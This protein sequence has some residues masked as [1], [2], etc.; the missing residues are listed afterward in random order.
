MSPLA[1]SSV[2]PSATPAAVLP[3]ISANQGEVRPAPGRSGNVQV[4]RDVPRVLSIAGSDPSGG[5]GVQADLKSI[6]A[7]G[8]YGMAAITAL[9]VQNTQGVQAVH[10]PPASFL[11]QQ[12]DAISDDITIDAV[13]IGMLGDAAV[14]G[15]VRDWLEKARPAVVVLDPVMVATSGDRLLHESAEAALRE[16]LPLADLI[17]PNLAELAILVGEPQARDWPDALGQGQRLSASAGATVLVKGGHL[18]G[19]ACPDALVNAAGLLAQEVVE[20]SGDRIPTRNSHGTG[21][22]L[23]SAMATAQARL[24]NWES[25]LR[26][27]KPWLVGALQAA[28][29]LEVGGGHGPINHFH[30]MKQVPAAGEFAQTLQR[31]SAPDLAAIFG[32]DFIRDLAGGTLA[33]E[34]FGYYL[35]Q[36]AI[37]LNG[38]SRVLARASA[39]APTEA[40]QTFWAKSARQC[41]EV[42]SELHRTWLS[43]RTVN[44]ALGPVTKSYVDHL[45]AASASGSYAVLVAAVLPCFWLYAEV[46]QTLHAEFLA[47][48]APKEH[49]YADWLRAYADEDFAQATRDAIALADEAGRSASTDERAAMLVAFRQSCRFE[50]EFFDAPRIH[51]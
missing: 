22:S 48:G 6:A 5:A 33:E 42:E 16:L 17:T 23:S 13:K 39:L 27:V 29:Q 14:I 51:S 24:G 41:L 43:T 34:E 18:D 11:G 21:C 36:D 38:Y 44:S 3:D 4:L 15:V 9:T 31:A 40:A 28:D 12:L 2:L 26:H 50:V 19:G 47:A 35:A 7:L 37:Y 20:V 30:H 8:G 49:P 10:V 46:G 32:L 1:S 25:A 45:L